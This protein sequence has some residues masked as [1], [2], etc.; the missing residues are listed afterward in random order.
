MGRENTWRND[1]DLI[2]GFGRQTSVNEAAAGV[3]T[4]GKE[5][6]LI[7]VLNWKDLRLSTDPV[8]QFNIEIPAGAIILSAVA[9]VTEVFSSAVEV[10]TTQVDNGDKTAFGG[11]AD[12]TA[13]G[14]NVFDVTTNAN[15]ALDGARY[16]YADGTALTSGM[17][18]LV[19]K[20]QMA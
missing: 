15:D 11:L 2:V 19:V 18:E 5:N 1:D 7:T 9:N 3:H 10:G 6:E 20:W 17:A 4:Y 12:L 14:S 16:V 8:E 13:L